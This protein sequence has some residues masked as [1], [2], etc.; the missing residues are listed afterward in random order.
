VAEDELKVQVLPLDEIVSGV[1][2]LLKIDVEGMAVAVLEG[3]QRVVATNRPLIVVEV[4]VEEMP[5]IYYWASRADYE[6]IAALADYAGLTNMVFRP[7]TSTGA[8]KRVV[9]EDSEARV[10]RAMSQVAVESAR[11]KRADASAALAH[12]M[13]NQAAAR[14]Q[15]AANEAREVTAQLAR[16]SAELA[17]L[18]Q[19]EA[20]FTWRASYPLRRVLGVMP[21]PWRRALRRTEEASQAIARAVGTDEQAAGVALD[22]ARRNAQLARLRQVEASLTW[23]ARY[24]VRRV[25]GVVPLPLRRR[26]RGSGERLVLKLRKGI[27]A[28]ETRRGAGRPE[29]SAGPDHPDWLAAFRFLTGRQSNAGG[30]GLAA[31]SRALRALVVDSRWPEPDRDSGSVDAMN[32]ITELLRLGYETTFYALSLASDGKY[33]RR[34]EELGVTC[35]PT[36]SSGPLDRFLKTD[37]EYLALCVLNRV[38]AGGQFFEAVRLLAGNSRVVFNTVDLHFLRE[39]RAARLKGDRRGLVLAAATRERELYLVRQ[40]DATMVVSSEERNLL[41]AAVPGARVFEFPLARE[42]HRPTRSF[43]GRSGVGFV[44]GF[45][46][47]P[48]VDAI[49]FFISEVWPIILRE[50]PG[51]EFMIAGADLPPNILRPMPERVRYC[52]HVGDLSAWFD[53]LR[54]SVAPLRYGAGAKG[55]V[56]S[57]LAHGVPCVATPLAVEGMQLGEGDGVLVHTSPEGL[58][59]QI[60]DAYNDR[61]LWSD[62]SAAGL[63][64]AQN[65]LSPEQWRR[66]FEGLL[67]TIGLP[68]STALRSVGNAP[69]IA[70]RP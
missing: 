36:A 19:I 50:L 38:H 14:A 29:L 3:A 35:L 33:R 34:L 7:A 25:L 37:G 62:L 51:C 5:A 56:A 58:A 23:R 41:E 54:L 46:H 45:A 57:S 40:A 26:L 60:V 13:A 31:A 61:K 39:E 63:E 6:L 20:S 17:R 4:S 30:P 49:Q 1:V 10:A 22:L 64:F 9:A 66:R 42:L 44:G 65:Q 70:P 18:R 27:R 53:L 43:E 28:V 52:G 11:A 15:A 47:A 16:R 32:M 21:A 59:R 69:Y 12:S 24:A 8:A 48:N 68:P 67:E 55:K 2:D